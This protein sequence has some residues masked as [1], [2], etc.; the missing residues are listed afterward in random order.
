MVKKFSVK[1]LE[2]PGNDYVSDTQYVVKK[3]KLSAALTISADLPLVPSEVI[4]N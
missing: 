4:D 1:V 2:T 3:L